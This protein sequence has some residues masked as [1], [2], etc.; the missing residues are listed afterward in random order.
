MKLLGNDMT[1][2]EVDL[3][4]KTADTDH[5]GSINIKE[6]IAFALDDGVHKYT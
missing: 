3:I 4:I 2:E 1:D 5:D 6:F